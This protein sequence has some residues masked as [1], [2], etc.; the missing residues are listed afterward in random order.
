V[1]LPEFAGYALFGCVHPM[2]NVPAAYKDLSKNRGGEFLSCVI[3]IPLTLL[4]LPWL[5]TVSLIWF[6]PDQRIVKWVA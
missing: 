1:A 5:A 2:P 6:I 3:F 4:C